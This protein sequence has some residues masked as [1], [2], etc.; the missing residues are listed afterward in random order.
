M[1]RREFITL[2]GGAARGLE[3]RSSPWAGFAHMKP[4]VAIPLARH[5]ESPAEAGPVRSQR[6][7]PLMGYPSASV[8]RGAAERCLHRIDHRLQPR[9]SNLI[10][11][12][13]ANLA[14]VPYYSGKARM[15]LQENAT[16]GSRPAR[17]FTP[18]NIQKI[19][20]WV[21]AGISREEIAKSLHVTV[22]SLQVTCSRLGISL[23]RRDASRPRGPRTVRRHP[24]IAGQRHTGTGF[25]IALT[26]E[27]NGR[28]QTTE[29]PLTIS[30]IV[31]LKLEAEIRN[32]S[33]G[34]LLAEVAS[35]AIKGDDRRDST[36][37]PGRAAPLQP[38]NS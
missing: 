10:Q 31:R 7:A 8:L 21:A 23:R 6:S 30:A 29:L 25:Q 15:T 1:R 16:T 27:C 2:L 28:R 19:K 22:G 38:E 11:T 36:R 14:Q 35:M 17:K 12:V 13:A 26:L 5:K 24:P 33:M 32:L 9:V 20:D 18:A 37:A 34:Q 4:D 3:P